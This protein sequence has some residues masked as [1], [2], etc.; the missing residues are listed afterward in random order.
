MYDYYLL[1]NKYLVYRVPKSGGYNNNNIEFIDSISFNQCGQ[2]WLKSKTHSD[3]T[4][5]LSV[6]AS[7]LT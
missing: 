2:T 1:K 7:L 6:G 5:L 3:T 4:S